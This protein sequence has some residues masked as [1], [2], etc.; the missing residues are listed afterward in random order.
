MNPHNVRTPDE[1]RLQSLVL[2]CLALAALE[3]SIVMLGGVDYSAAV[4]SISQ[5]LI[6][7]S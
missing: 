7:F 2:S 4:S 6:Y 1:E 3:G 5:S